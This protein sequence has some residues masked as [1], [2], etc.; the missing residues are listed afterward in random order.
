VDARL[1]TERGHPARGKRFS[2]RQMRRRPGKLCAFRA[3]L[4]VGARVSVSRQGRIAGRRQDEFYID[5]QAVY[6]R[7]KFEGGGN[8]SFYIRK[9]ATRQGLL[10]L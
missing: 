6:K 8:S 2:G 5:R 1:I 9:D 7:G 3:R 4:G 10:C